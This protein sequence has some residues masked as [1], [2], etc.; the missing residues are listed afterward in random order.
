MAC[1]YGFIR[2]K[3]KEAAAKAM[4]VL[5]LQEMKEYPGQKVTHIL[6]NM[7]PE[8][9]LLTSISPSSVNVD[10]ASLCRLQLEHADAVD[11]A[12]T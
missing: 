11:A 3:T 5:H 4:E 10:G 12:V 1:R 6:V 8:L 7:I 2:Y 9:P